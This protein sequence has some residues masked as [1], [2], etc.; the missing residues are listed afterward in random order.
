[1]QQSRS[2]VATSLLAGC[3][4]Y[5]AWA[6]SRPGRTPLDWVWIGLMLAAVVW[7]LVALGRRLYRAG[8]GAAVWHLHRTVLFWI[9]GLRN[10]VLIRPEDIGSWRN[11]VGWVFVVVAAFDTLQLGRRERAAAVAAPTMDGHG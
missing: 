10:T 9:V 7:N 8:G 11:L 5:F 4:L 1:M 6:F 3:A 2:Y